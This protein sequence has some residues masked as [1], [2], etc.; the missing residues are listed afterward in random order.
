[1]KFSFECLEVYQRAIT[2]SADVEFILERAG[3]T[4]SLSDL[5]FRA[6]LSIP[7]NI[8]EGTG[9]RPKRQKRNYYWAARGAAFECI[10][11]IEILFVRKIISASERDELRSKL[12]IIGKMLCRLSEAQ[13]KAM[14]IENQLALKN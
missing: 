1:M 14:V 6:A 4:K 5:L 7:L 8:A 9:H 3:L 11:L 10:P 2:F 12:V 13:D